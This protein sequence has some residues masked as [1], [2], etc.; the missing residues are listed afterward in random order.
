MHVT[1]PKVGQGRGGERRRGE[2]GKRKGREGRKVVEEQEGEGR[3]REGKHFIIV[4]TMQH[5]LY[6]AHWCWLGEGR[7]APVPQ[8]GDV[9]VHTYMT[10]LLCVTV[11]YD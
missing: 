1:G 4:S 11:L 7:D 10:G 3:R 9:Y 5:N 8:C 2:G 6:C